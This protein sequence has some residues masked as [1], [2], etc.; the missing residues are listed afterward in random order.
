MSFNQLISMFLLVIFLSINFA[1][2]FCN[3]VDCKPRGGEVSIGVISNGANAIFGDDPILTVEDIL[4]ST[5][6]RDDIFFNNNSETID[7]FL[8]SNIL[9]TIRLGNIASF[10]LFAEAERIAN[11]RCCDVFEISRVELDGEEICNL[12]C[13]TI[14]IEI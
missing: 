14:E 2:C 13:Q 8:E 7:L 11:G 10:E 5:E 4:I 1:A 3:K 12:D 9:Y 6:L